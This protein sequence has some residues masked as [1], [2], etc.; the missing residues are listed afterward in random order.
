[1]SAFDV[2]REALDWFYTHGSDPL[3]VRPGRLRGRRP[4]EALDSIESENLLLKEDIRVREESQIPVIP[5]GVVERF[6][7]IEAENERLR[8]ALVFADKLHAAYHDPR[9]A[10]TRELADAAA[11]Y[12]I[13][14][15]ATPEET[16][17]SGLRA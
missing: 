7:V 14:R 17:E 15:S 9:L 5:R 8:E 6:N 10:E 2:V 16:K 1:V 12:Q 3:A 13:A 4:W 11:R